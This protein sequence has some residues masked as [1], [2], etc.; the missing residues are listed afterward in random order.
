MQY[1]IKDVSEFDKFQKKRYP[2]QGDSCFPLSPLN[3]KNRE[4]KDESLSKKKN[5]ISYRD[6]VKVILK[7]LGQ[8]TEKDYSF[9]SAE[10]TINLV[11]DLE[12]SAANQIKRELDEGTY[13]DCESPEQYEP[14]I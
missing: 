4:V 10:N 3:M 8:Q 11:S 5:V 13:E 2:F 12:V 14:F 6:Q 7:G 9:L 1:T